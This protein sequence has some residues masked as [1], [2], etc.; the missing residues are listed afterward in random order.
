MV[1]TY[2]NLFDIS[3]ITEVINSISSWIT[4]KCFPFWPNCP[5][6]LFEQSLIA[7]VVACIAKVTLVIQVLIKGFTAIAVCIISS[8]GWLLY[9]NLVNLVLYVIHEVDYLAMAMTVIVENNLFIMVLNS[10]NISTFMPGIDPP[11]PN[12]PWKPYPA[13]GIVE[14][15]GGNPQPNPKPKFGDPGRK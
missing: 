1:L 12:W 7:S 9:N 15:K 6:N 13:P 3:V 11:K 5:N 4:F 14:P 2:I 8:T 10:D